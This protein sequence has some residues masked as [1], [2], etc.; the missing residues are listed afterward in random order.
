M[1]NQNL[2][3]VYFIN[4]FV[5]LKEIGFLPGRGGRVVEGARLESECTSQGYPGFESRSLRLED[6]T[7]TFKDYHLKLI[8]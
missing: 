6:K 7:V 4:L 8:T 3:K 5:C 2:D 1:I